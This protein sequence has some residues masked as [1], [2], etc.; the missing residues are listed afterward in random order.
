MSSGRLKGFVNRTGRSGSP[1]TSDRKA[2]QALKFLPKQICGGAQEL[3]GSKESSADHAHASNFMNV[4][5][6]QH[7]QHEQPLPSYENDY[8]GLGL[9]SIVDS[10]FDH[11]RTESLGQAP[12]NDIQLSAKDDN[13]LTYFQEGQRSES[14]FEQAQYEPFR[15]V[16][17]TTRL[18]EGNRQPTDVQYSTAGKFVPQD[19][20]PITVTKMAR[21]QSVQTKSHDLRKVPSN[22]PEGRTKRVSGKSPS[23]END[24]SDTDQGFLDDDEIGYEEKPLN[25][26][27]SRSKNQ[28]PDMTALNS[29]TENQT[30]IPLADY[31]D[32]TLKKMS[33]NEL[34]SQSW[35]DAPD[36]KTFSY[37]RELRGSATTLETKINYYLTNTFKDKN[38]TGPGRKAA[39][40]FYEQLTS[41]EWDE[42]GEIFIGKFTE[43]MHKLKEK[44]QEKRDLTH[45]F[46]S[47]IHA[48]ESAVRRKSIILD[49]KLHDMR[50][51]GESLLIGSPRT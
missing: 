40:A 10:D 12:D 2:A 36:K 25:L 33:Y 32:E 46:E 39:E 9:D 14:N 13:A 21:F 41:K 15:D 11:T 30:L 19:I 51:G 17:F 47:I 42:A 44:R 43:L 18:N 27:P 48:R 37:P 45:K 4:E 28:R 23:S 20:R 5:H 29:R 22:F 6:E 34:M 50:T 38:A 3:T 7:E 35:E 49:K 8:T 1:F 24:Y 26:T 16:N 31:D